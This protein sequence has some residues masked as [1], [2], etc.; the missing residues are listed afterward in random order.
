ME[1]LAKTSDILSI[2]DEKDAKLAGAKWPV[3]GLGFSGDEVVY[4]DLPFSQASAAKSLEVSFAIV[5][6]MHPRLRVALIR[7]A[8]LLDKA[9]MDVLC[10]LAKKYKMQVWLEE[11]AEF[12]PIDSIVIEDGTQKNPTAQAAPAKPKRTRRKKE[13]KPAEPES[14]S[15]EASIIV[16][17]PNQLKL[18]WES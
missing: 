14:S 2:D 6:A 15:S 8:S 11:V 5:S 3:G 18:P 17:A 7:D 10:S 12:G 4:D 1:S 9:H 13:A 16:A